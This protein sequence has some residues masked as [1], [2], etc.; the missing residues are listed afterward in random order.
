LNIPVLK[1]APF[2]L[3]RRGRPMFTDT[4]FM[5]IYLT[6]QEALAMQI[7]VDRQRPSNG[8]GAIRIPNIGFAS[9]R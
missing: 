3:I 8:D 4:S 9:V 2:Q 6:I 7:S 1:V 5:G